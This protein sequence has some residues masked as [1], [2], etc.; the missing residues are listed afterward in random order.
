[1]HTKM[2]RYLF[3]LLSFLSIAAS[4]PTPSS[5][6]LVYQFPNFTRL[7]NIAVRK[8]GNLLLTSL[9]GPSLYTLNPNAQNPQPSVIYQFPDTNSLY[10]I[11]E[12]SP[13][14]F[15]VVAGPSDP[16]TNPTFSVWTLNLRNPGPPVA[17]KAAT[18]PA[19]ATLNGLARLSKNVVLSSD[20]VAGVVYRID[21]SSGQS[22]I[23]LQDATL[24]PVPGVNGIRLKGQYLHFVNY[25][26]GIY[27]RVPINLQTGTATGPVE[28]IYEGTALM[29]ADDFALARKGDAAFIAVLD[30]NSLVKVT[31]AGTTEVVAGGADGALFVGPTSAQFGRK[32]GDRNVL[33]VVSSGARFNPATGMYEDVEGG[34]ITAVR[35]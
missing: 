17:N 34:K 25:G 1:M 32:A 16:A 7:E 28:I 27:A 23:A 4:T 18:M 31:G 11:T 9:S 21:L 6:Q 24:G 22:T 35:V 33:Y 30:Q 5:P 26:K 13:N 19:G 29:G 3:L 8:N 20:I 2:Y 14:I 10:G 15:A 12:L